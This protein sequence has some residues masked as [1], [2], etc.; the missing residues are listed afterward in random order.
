MLLEL[1]LLHLYL[2]LEPLDLELLELK[3]ERLR[4]LHWRLPLRQG[5]CEAGHVRARC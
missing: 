5:D 4:T 2:C 3:S 1:E